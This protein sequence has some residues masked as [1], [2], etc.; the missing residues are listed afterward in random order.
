MKTDNPASAPIPPPHTEKKDS[1][2]RL[3]AWETT[4][5]CNLACVHC[6]A[7]ATQ[8]PFSGELETN[9][10]FRLMDQIACVGKP[11]IILTGGE[12][13]LRA[14]I[15]DIAKYGADKGFRMVMAPN[16][17]L[18]TEKSARQMA[19]VGIQRISIDFLRNRQS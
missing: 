3:V 14:D 6:R 8:G 12:P 18:I 5:N 15:Y 10:S 13:L 2:L 1:A 17:T 16:G 9:A 11:I 7:S 4:R 19:D